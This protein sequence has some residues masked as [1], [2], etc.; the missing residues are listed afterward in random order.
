MGRATAPCPPAHGSLTLLARP[1]SFHRNGYEGQIGGDLYP[2][3]GAPKLKHEGGRVLK[4]SHDHTKEAAL[5]AA[6][7]QFKATVPDSSPD[8]P[9][10]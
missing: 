9:G 3:L 2:E 7:A 10:A 1:E 6:L 5:Q 4:T 8:L